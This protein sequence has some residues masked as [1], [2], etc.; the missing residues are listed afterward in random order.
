[1]RVLFVC[2]GNTC[3]SPLAEALARAAAARRGLAVEVASA[4]LAALPG[5]PAAEE[6][7]RVAAE[8]GLDLEAHRARRLDADLVAGADAILTMTPEQADAVRRRFP[9]VSGRVATV[10]AAAGLAPPDADAGIDDPVGLGIE[11]YRRTAR[12][13][14]EAVERLADAWEAVASGRPAPGGA[15]GRG[16]GAASPPEPRDRG[17]PPEGA[18]A[19]G[20]CRSG[21]RDA[22][23]RERRERVGVVI[24]ADHAGFALKEAI[25]GWLT[26]WG[27]PHRDVGAEVLDPGDDYPDFAARVAAAVAGGE[28]ER[29]IL[30]CG[31]GI[32][33]SIAAN[34][35]PGVRAAVCRDER[36]A[37]ASREHNDANVLCLGGRFTEEG[38][39]REIVRTW[40]ETPFAGGRHERRVRKIRGLEDG[41]AGARDVPSGP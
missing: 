31:S 20:P 28:A 38:A 37:R 39:A 2:T 16:A 7:R 25:K 26:E 30:V 9:E 41:L 10:L 4:G 33:M 32:G 35:V 24:G 3:R 40:L 14:A 21:A 18:P 11:A 29:G 12:L 19:D 8:R 27:I 5:A 15:G 6:A 34:K 13:L 23:G 22:G 1:M 17:R 36:D